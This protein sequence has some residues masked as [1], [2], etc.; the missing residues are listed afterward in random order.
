MARLPRKLI[1]MILFLHM[2]KAGFLMTGL[3]YDKDK[4][5]FCVS[6]ANIGVRKLRKLKVH[7]FNLLHSLS[8]KV[9]Q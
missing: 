7:A 4:S 6:L 2:Q 9:Y 1:C 3:I 5:Q 8:I